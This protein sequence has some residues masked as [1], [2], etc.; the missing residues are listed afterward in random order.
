MTVE[1]LVARLRSAS[2]EY[3]AGTPFMSDEAF[4]VLVAELRA[5][6]P[7]HAFLREVGSP[8]V[9]AKVRHRH[10]MGGLNK[11]AAVEE[12]R[13]W[14]EAAGR[15]A[16]VVMAKLDGMSLDLRYGAGDAL[17]QALTRGDGAEGEDV[18]GQARRVKGASARVAGFSGHVRGEVVVLK[19]DFRVHFKGYV[20]ERNAATGV[21]KRLEDPE[22][23]ASHL[24]FVAYE[25]LPDGPAPASKREELQRLVVAG[26]AVPRPELCASFSDVESCYRYMVEGGGRDRLPYLADGLVLVVDDRDAREALGEEGGCPRGTLALKFPSQGAKAVLRDVEWQV[27]AAGR[28][29]P[30]AVLEPVQVCGVTVRRASLH[31]AAAV[32]ALAEKAGQGTLAVGDVVLVTRRGD[33]IPYVEELLVPAQPGLGG[34]GKP[35]EV[36]RV[37]SACRHPLRFEGEYLICANRNLC[38]AQ[39]TGAVK[40]WLR[41]VGVKGWGDA[42]VEALCV[43]GLVKTVADLYRLDEATLAAVE[44]GGRRLGPSAARACLES[45]DDHSEVPLEVLVG[46]LGIPHWGREM[47]GVLV[48]AGF[49]T[50]EK[51][52]S[53]QVVAIEDVHGVGPVRALAFDEGFRERRHLVDDLLAVGVTVTAWATGP[54]AGEVVCFTGFR[55]ET[56]RR[57]VEAA[58]GA[59][60]DGFSGKVTVLVALDPTGRSAKLDKARAAGVKVVGREAA[61]A[62]ARS[63]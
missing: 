37:C 36:P 39:T 29:T 63:R 10:Y 19:E 30:V 51:L 12:A 56:L 9:G 59:Y 1:E 50:V 61:F 40:T 17:A 15:P 26:F 28:V 57:A 54:L 18:T 52:A 49:D 46:S 22:D 48:A 58:G 55:D 31:N 53:A 47:V 23:M 33:V 2:R 45:L 6:D 3:Y 43:S 7:R 62:M 14:H 42:L 44:L 5:L 13:A 11:V 41:K 60:K 8:P 20:N 16:L 24:T 38:E 34:L 32:R 25:L 4:D 27:G 35:L 21:M